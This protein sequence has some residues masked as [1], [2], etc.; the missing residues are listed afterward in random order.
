M[1]PDAAARQAGVT[2]PQDYA[3]LDV[4]LLWTEDIPVSPQLL[5]EREHLFQEYSFFMN[6]PALGTIQMWPTTTWQTYMPLA[7]GGY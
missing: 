6:N 2:L 7:G 4:S 5:L 1:A 3:L